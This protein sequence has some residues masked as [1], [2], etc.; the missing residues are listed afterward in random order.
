VSKAQQVARHRGI[1]DD[2]RTQARQAIGHGR[3]LTASVGASVRRQQQ[4]E[5]EKEQPGIAI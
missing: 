3:M 4:V 2:E 5:R 1:T